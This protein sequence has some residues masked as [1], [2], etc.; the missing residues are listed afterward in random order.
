MGIIKKL[1]ALRKTLKA[2]GLADVLYLRE[3][4]NFDEKIAATHIA[5]Y[6][7]FRDVREEEELVKFLEGRYDYLHN[8]TN[9]YKESLKE[10]RRAVIRL[11]LPGFKGRMFHFCLDYFIPFLERKSYFEISKLR[12]KYKKE[13]MM[14]SQVVNL[15]YNCFNNPH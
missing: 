1:K 6:Y 8:P 7:Y 15:T 4:F 5:T 12:E 14:L 13:K 10:Q 2:V 9:I 11:L 3:S